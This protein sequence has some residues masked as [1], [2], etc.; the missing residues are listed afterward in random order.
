MEV[1]TNYRHYETEVSDL[2]QNPQTSTSCIAVLNDVLSSLPL[3]SVDQQANSLFTKLTHLQAA[4]AALAIATRVV[5]KTARLLRL[6]MVSRLD[7]LRLGL[8]KA[9]EGLKRCVRALQCVDGEFRRWK[10]TILSRDSVSVPTP[11]RGTSYHY[12]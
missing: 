3:P 12:H 6:S 7:G 9:Q 10:Q 2:F 4:S 5:E 8:M 11:F 1:D